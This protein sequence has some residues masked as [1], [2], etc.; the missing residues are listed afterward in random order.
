MPYT[1]PHPQSPHVCPPKLQRK[2]GGVGVGAFLF[3]PRLAR[4]LWT[5]WLD[6]APPTSPETTLSIGLLKVLDQRALR[7]RTQLL[8][9]LID[10]AIWWMNCYMF[11]SGRN[12]MFVPFITTLVSNSVNTIGKSVSTCVRLKTRCLMSPHIPPILSSS[13]AKPRLCDYWDCV[14]LLSFKVSVIHF[15]GIT[16]TVLWLLGFCFSFFFTAMWYISLA[17]CDIVQWFLEFQVVFLFA[18]RLKG[19]CFPS[20][21]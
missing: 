7:F 13:L 6:S 4:L 1:W 8:S 15:M 17:K 12:A 2:L 20:V 9:L 21:M 19:L 14:C 11:V 10:D 5:V 16:I 3:S 18:M